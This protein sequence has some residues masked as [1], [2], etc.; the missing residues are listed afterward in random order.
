MSF[1]QW[2][3]K[4]SVGVP[5]LD[6]DHKRLIDIINRL[7]EHAGDETKESVLRQALY[8][9]QRY[10]E[11]HFRREEAVMSACSFKGLDHHKQEHLAFV[12]RISTLNRTFEVQG[13]NAA[14]SLPDDLL[15]YLRDWLNHHILIEDMAYRRAAENNPEAR[16]AARAFRPTELWWGSSSDDS[17]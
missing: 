2:S 7:A 10:A 13:K 3:Q 15:G 6:D 17:G 4:M 8:G 16:R 12:E 11:V 14:S 5:E 9:L 1:M